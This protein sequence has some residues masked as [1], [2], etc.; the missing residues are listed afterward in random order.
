MKCVEFL[1]DIVS[2]LTGE[3]PGIEVEEDEHGAVITLTISGNVSALIGKHG[4]T[5]DAVRTLAK[6][7]GYNDKHR[8]KIR[9]HEH[10]ATQG[11]QI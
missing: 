11:L 3:A 7:I 10:G 6:A 8:I 5:I 1:N 9:I 4:A 2:H